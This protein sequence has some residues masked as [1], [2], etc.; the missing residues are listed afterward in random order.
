MRAAKLPYF[1]RVLLFAFFFSFGI[2]FYRCL[3]T[4]SLNY[5]FF[6]W[7]LLIA[8]VPYI[9]SKRLSTCKTLNAKA[10]F[11]LTL[12]LLF[13]PGCI[14]L[15]TDMLQMHET[16]FP[17]IYDV[18]MFLSFAATGMLPGLMS[19][20]KVETFLSHHISGLFV[21]LSILLSIFLSSYNIVLVRFLHLKSWN[22]VADC[23]RMLHASEKDILFPESNMHTWISIFILVLLIDLV[24][25][26]FKQL[27]RFERVRII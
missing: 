18:C 13:F 6:L 12:W 5:T 4:L 8:F 16:N 20:K 1:E 22:I 9:I 10:L 21:K 26:G 24:Y 23:K 7:N 15:F 25:A 19:L 14:Y 3:F 17:I 2:L 27:N 11:L